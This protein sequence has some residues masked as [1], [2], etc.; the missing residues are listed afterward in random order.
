M[1]KLLFGFLAL[2]IIQS[3]KDN[4]VEL[5]EVRIKRDTIINQLTDS[6]YFGDVRSIYYTNN[7]YYMSDFKRNQV[8]ILNNNLKLI[9]IFGGEGRGPGE[10]VGASQI[11]VNSDSIF[12]GNSYKQC[13]EVFNPAGYIKTINL[14][15]QVS[16][17][18][19]RFCQDGGNLF[20]TTGNSRNSICKYNYQRDTIIFFGKQTKYNTSKETRIKNNRHILKFKNKIIAVPNCHPKIEL[21]DMN[22]NFI[23]K[24]DISHL[25]PVNKIM[26]Y[27]DRQNYEENTYHQFIPDAYISKNKLYILLSTTTINDHIKRKLI[28]FKINDREVKPIRLLNMG[29]GL[30]EPICIKEDTLLTFNNGRLIKYNLN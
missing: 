5:Q 30:F 26:N 12:V 20:M 7:R 9:N 23:S 11:Y 25:K 8:F 28:E 18:S 1:K 4:E 17:I 10:F 2:L 29:E 13:I 3:C 24:F 6:S 21:Y 19:T 15:S 22:G 14:K 27:I 16:L